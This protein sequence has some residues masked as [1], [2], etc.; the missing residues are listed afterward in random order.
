MKRRRISANLV[1]TPNKI[2]KN[3]IIELNEQGEITAIIENSESREFASTEFYNGVLVPGFINTHSHLE[4]SHLENKISKH[5]GLTGF[6]EELS[7]LRND[8]SFEQ[9]YAAQK[10]ALHHMQNEGI[11][12]IGDISNGAET[13]LLKKEKSSIFYFHTFVELIGFDNYT[14]ESDLARGISLVNQF[15]LFSNSS[16]VPHAMYSVSANLLKAIAQRAKANDDVVSIHN[17]ETPSEDLLMQKKQGQ[18]F[19]FLHKRSNTMSDLMNGN[20]SSETAVSLFNEAKS[21]MLIHNTFTKAD[22]I[23]K[24]NNKNIY[25]TFC[26]NAN[27]YIENT[28]PDMSLWKKYSDS[29]CLGTDS[30]ASNERLSILSEMRT[31]QNCFPEWAFE[32][33]LNWATINGAKALGIDSKYGSFEIGKAPGINLITSFDFKYLKLKPTSSI[34][35]II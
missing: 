20:T 34:K 5:T 8:F 2:L 24:V 25:W 28:L 27:L 1:F 32:E 31:I 7:V 15:K 11:V 23:A 29:V 17:Q 33:L 14:A 22:E 4:L 26:P 19:E 12:A 30:W 10:K 16:V 18:L 21:L 35:K 6:I 9:K 3:G 13:L